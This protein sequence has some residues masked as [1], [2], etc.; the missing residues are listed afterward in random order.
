MRRMVLDTE[1]IC[2][3]AAP[4][5]VP[6]WKVNPQHP[7]SGDRLRFDS[8][9]PVDRGGVSAFTDEDH[10]ALHVLRRKSG[11]DPHHRDHRNVDDREDVHR[12]A[13]QRQHAED[14]DQQAR[15]GDGVRA[16]QRQSN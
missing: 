13:R 6:G 3:M 5:S 8:R 4:I 14:H 11:I 16:P 9:N 10:A 12:H 15:D 2:A 7:N 1:E